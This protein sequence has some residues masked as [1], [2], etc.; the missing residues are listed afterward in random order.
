MTDS[1]LEKLRRHLNN[2]IQDEPGAV[3]LLVQ[4]RKILERHHKDEPKYGALRMYCHWALHSELSGSGTIGPFLLRVDRWAANFL[5]GFKDERE[6]NVVEDH[7]LFT[8]FLYLDSFRSQLASL[9]ADRNLPDVLTQD[10]SAWNAF[11]ACYG[12]VIEDIPLRIKAP[13]DIG[14]LAVSKVTFSKGKPLP[15]EHHVP[16]EI[17]WR[18]DLKDGRALRTTLNDVPDGWG[19]MFVSHIQLFSPP[20]LR[21]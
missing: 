8:E 20:G 7:E 10:R 18:V 12:G 4:V 11:M 3:Y 17:E 16:F 2:G 9:L 13:G 21:S 15:S 5:P 1:I 6:T 14:L 19:S